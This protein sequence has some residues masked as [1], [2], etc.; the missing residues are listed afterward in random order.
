MSKITIKDTKQV[1]FEAYERAVKELSEANA[2]KFDPLADKKAKEV[3]AIKENAKAIV[4]MNILNESIIAKYK[5]LE[6]AIKMQES[7]LEEYYGI[8][9]EVD[10]IL[11][12][13]EAKKEIEADLDTKYEAKKAEWEKS[14]DDLIKTYDYN[15]ELLRKERDR[16]KEEYDYKLK[17]DRQIA[18]DKWS[19]EK[20]EREAA[21]SLKE[22][23]V[24]AREEA[25]KAAETELAELKAKVE[26]IPSLI[27][28][29]TAEA[30]DKAKKEADKAKAIE[31]NVVKRELALEKTLLEKE[32]EAL[33]E[34]NKR[35]EAQN[36]DLSA[37]LETAQERVQ[38]IAT[39]TVKASQPRLVETGK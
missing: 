12:L 13:I 35:L 38:A 25:V 39:E 34:A 28:Q 21:L 1:I 30:A 24:A 18:N 8:K 26:E 37:K 16:E 31:I 23:G 9:K 11:A 33:K 2:G 36:A 19:D 10:S 15:K 32:M 27:S 29:A 5:D 20:A 17:R 14:I 4:D 22:A 3:K 7:E 6:A